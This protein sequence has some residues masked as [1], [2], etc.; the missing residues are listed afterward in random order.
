MQMKRPLIYYFI[1]VFIGCLSS[2]LLYENALIGAVVAASFFAIFFF[3]LNKNFFMINMIFFI[4]GM[5]SFILYFNVKVCNPIELR[6][7]QNKGY[8]CLGYYK[9]RKVA[10]NGRIDKVKEGEILRVYGKFQNNKDYPRGIIGTY[11]IE[12]YETCNKD[13]IYYLYE[14]KRNMYSQFKEKLGEDKS[15]LIMALC[16]GDASYLSKSQNNDFKKMGVFHAI[17]VSGFHMAIIYKV[18]EFIVGLKFAILTSFGYLIFTGMQ[19]S[20]IRAFIMILVFKLSK[21]FFKNYDSLSSMGLAGL[22]LIISKPYYIM[23]IGFM[24]SF[25]ATLG[26]LLYYKKLLRIL[27]K[28]PKSLN[29]SLSITL[30]SQIFSVPYTAFNIQSFSSGFILGNILLLPMYSVIVIMGNLALLICSVPIIF[31]ILARI[32]NFMLTAVEGANYIILKVCPPITCLTYSDGFA[33]M[34]IYLSFLLYKHGHERFKYFPLFIFT[35]MLFQ[36]YSFLPRIYYVNFYK[37]EGIIVEYKMSKV[38]VCNYDQSYAK[39]VIAI[40][41]KMNID[42][43]ITNPKQRFKTN[44]SGNLYLN[45]MPCDEETSLNII[46]SD[47][48]EKFAFISNNMKNSALSVFKPEDLTKF[49]KKS[50]EN[51]SLRN[52]EHNIE[53]DLVMYVI[54]FKRII[55]VY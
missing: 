11:K 27:Y 50:L 10:L 14:I 52:K 37:G 30:S 44:V 20:T 38:M 12:K 16:Y 40:K 51:N 1:S 42:K 8:Y 25:L 33:L 53:E 35:L 47:A 6:I 43:I 3:T 26:I 2:L 36:D 41:E 46:I 18:L 9:G 48:D 45:V 15:A 34:G 7:V 21:T 32:L 5:I 22:I 29:E 13:I 17:S 54:I 49:P 23:D 55:R 39:E 4:V 31:D 19:A 28:L 24:L